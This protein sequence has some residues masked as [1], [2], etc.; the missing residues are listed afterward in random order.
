V[1]DYTVSIDPMYEDL[2]TSHEKIVK[3]A[4]TT[5][6]L[7]VLMT[8]NNQFAARAS[9]T[10]SSTGLDA[11]A[12]RHTEELKQRRADAFERDFGRKL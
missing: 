3:A 7:N 8:L 9:H 11:N 4:I 10:V 6:V 2:F 5:A 1:I 12:I